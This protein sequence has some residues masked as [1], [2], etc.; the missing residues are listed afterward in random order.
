MLKQKNKSVDILENKDLKNKRVNDSTSAYPL[1]SQ[2]KRGERTEPLYFCV[3]CE[4]N[5]LVED[6]LTFHLQHMHKK[7]QNLRAVAAKTILVADKTRINCPHCPKTYANETTLSNHI[8]K[9][10]M[11]LAV[12]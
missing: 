5:F 10:H 1:R 9:Y 7:A 3:F 4:K 12:L 8:R 6:E 11:T 2:G